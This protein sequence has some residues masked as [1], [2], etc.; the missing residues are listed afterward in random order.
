MKTD[1]CIV[2]LV[3]L[4]DFTSLSSGECHANKQGPTNMEIKIIQFLVVNRSV[5]AGDKLTVSKKY[6]LKHNNVFM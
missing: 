6:C 3:F 2:L 1:G 4:L 5:H